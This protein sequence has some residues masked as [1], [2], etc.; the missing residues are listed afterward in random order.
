MVKKIR[1]NARAAGLGELGAALNATLRDAFESSGLSEEEMS[2][3]IE[4]ATL[5]A[6]PK[7]TAAMI[8]ALKR[9]APK[10]LRD[11]RKEDAG[12]TSRNYRRWR[13]AF[14]LL[15]MMWML[16]EEVGSA[17]N[18]EHRP[19]AAKSKDYHFEALTF[20]HARSLLVTREIICL[21]QGGF[22]DGAM[23]RWRTLHE[24]AVTGAFL[25][26]NKQEISHR[27]L[28]SR[29]FA[30]YRA[31]KDAKQ[32]AERANLEP[33]SDAEMEEMKKYCDHFA[34]L[35][36]KE[37]SNDYGWA[38]PVFNGNPKPNFRMI[39]EAVKLDHW[40]PRY[41]WASQHVHSPHRPTHA[42]L[43]M[44]EARQ[45]VFLVGQSNSGM[46]DPIQMT[47]I[48]LSI[49]TSNL[50]V[51][52]PTFDHIIAMNILDQ[53]SREI[54]PLALDIERKTARKGVVSP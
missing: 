21:M 19:D 5:E 31:A 3:A 28:A 29:F 42:L 17:Q 49:A 14:D 44:A 50:L 10:L 18:S 51:M 47:A 13:K 46:V 43:G 11:H 1:R 23:S 41:R 40:R 22:P 35:F 2:K 52:K 25:Q 32:H 34:A 45:Q 26:K 36:G 53:W 15:E 37:M 27:Y 12:F 4:D 39:E 9:H 38:S 6:I 48:S 24:L 30:S 20:L 7:T 54:G 16:S 33:F 8:K